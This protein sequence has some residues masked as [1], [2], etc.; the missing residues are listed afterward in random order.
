MVFLR[1]F[2]V[3][4]VLALCHGSALAKQDEVSL[5]SASRV[6]NAALRFVRVDLRHKVTEHDVDAGYLLFEY[7]DRGK[8]YPGSIE[9]IQ[10]GPKTY[11]GTRIVI[12]IPAMPSYIE[13]M[14]LNKLLQKLK[15]DYGEAVVPRKKAEEDTKNKEQK[16]AE[17]D[18]EKKSS[19][20]SS[21][22]KKTPASSDSK[23]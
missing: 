15:E 1:F 7:E 4:A 2:L 20:K 19:E 14:L 3:L 6:W 21:E 12:S 13:R 8:T 23:N 10:A 11:D 22:Q 16:P 5:H 17:E 18:Q 9:C